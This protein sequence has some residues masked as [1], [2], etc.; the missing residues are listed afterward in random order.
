MSG[1]SN[2]GDKTEY[3]AR[4][5]YIPLKLVEKEKLEALYR[6]LKIFYPGGFVT[7]HTDVGSFTR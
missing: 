7:K 4:T 5:V 1:D 6:Q 3:S 2:T